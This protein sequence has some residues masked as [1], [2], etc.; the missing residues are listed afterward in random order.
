MKRKKKIIII[1]IL[2]LLILATA[3]SWSGGQQEKAGVSKDMGPV[4]LIHHERAMPVKKEYTER[5]ASLFVKENPNIEIEVMVIPPAEYVKKMLILFASGTV[6]DVL[7][8]VS[9]DNF[10]PYASKQQLLNLDPFVEND[11]YDLKQFYNTSIQSLRYKG[12]LYALPSMMH[13]GHSGLYYN[14]DAFDQAG[15]DYPNLEWDYD[16]LLRTAKKLTIDKDND[17]KT[18]QYALDALTVWAKVLTVIRSF[19]G[20]FLD[21]DGKKCLV[22]EPEAI[23]AIGWVSDLINKHSFA[24]SPHPAH[25]QIAFLNTVQKFAAGIT[26]MFYSG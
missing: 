18:D 10:G 1:L 19:G 11:N 9:S 23:E 26:T 22:T 7:W 2:V 24:L 13:P 12:Q 17:G 15:I 16:N 21:P 8:L 3:T 25:E 20:D 5:M 4:K 6:G 14:V